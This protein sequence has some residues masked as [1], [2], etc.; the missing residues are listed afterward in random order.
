VRRK[1]PSLFRSIATTLAIALFIFQAIILSVAIYFVIV[2]MAKRSADDLAALMILSAQTWTEL[3][4]ETRDDFERELAKKHNLWLF[5]T[6]K[7]LPEEVHFLPYLYFFEHALEKRT[8]KPIKIKVTQW[9]QPWYW[10]DIPVA[11]MSIRIGFP[12]DHIGARPPQALALVLGV[13][14]VLTLI[15]S[16]ILARRISRPLSRLASAAKRVGE[17][18]SPL[19]LPETGTKELVDLTH[20]FNQ[21]A[22][23]VKELLDN[24]TTLLAGISHDLRTPLARMRIAVEM[25]PENTNPKV[26]QR[27]QYDIEEMNRLIGEFLDLSRG[28]GKEPT[29]KIDLHQLLDELVTDAR[30]GGGNIE[31]QSQNV[32][33]RAVAPIALRRV[34][35]NL[36]EN[37]VRYS[38]H[39][40]VSVE[41]TCSGTEVILSVLDRGPGIP[42]DKLEYVF[43]PFYRLESSRSNVTGGTGLGLAI[44]KQL[45]DANGWWITLLPRNGGGTEARL[46][47]P[48]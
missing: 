6:N 22:Y 41:C 38:N 12:K 28:L 36:I 7:P 25:L 8:G 11:G 45:A 42:P 35:T 39:K 13:T 19:E 47:I 48:A 9:K 34:L 14:I 16:V 43:R 3:P 18:A 37:A 4:A 1:R 44:A 33:E 46:T 29:Q 40:A 31:L 5:S 23:Q 20:T 27:L 17:G 32:C 2:P 10:A 24:R 21:M 26:A 15:V 30:H